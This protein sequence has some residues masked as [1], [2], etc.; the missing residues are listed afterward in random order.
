MATAYHA[1]YFAHE[2]TRR[3]P[4]DS[5]DRL[6]M[7]LFDAAVDLNPHQIDAALFALRS[8]LSKGVLLADE[9]GLGK[10]IEAGLVLC[11]LW[12]ERRRRLLVICPASIR[13]QWSLELQEK[14]NL[15]AVVLDR[16][17]HRATRRQGNPAP[18]ETD[19]I[20]IVS[21]N[22]ASAMQEEVR[23]TAWDLVIIDEAHKLRNAYRPSNRMGQRLRW[24][25]EDRRKVLLTATPLQNTL[26]E[27]YG[28]S[29]L[30]DDHI[31]GDR[32]SFQAQF[33]GQSGDQVELRRRLAGFT[34]RTLRNQVLEY[35]RYT[36]RRALTPCSQS[37]TK[38]RGNSS[39]LA[40][41]FKGRSIASAA[42]LNT[43]QAKK[44][45]ATSRRGCVLSDARWTAA[46]TTTPCRRRGSRYAGPHV[47]G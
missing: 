36:Q 11:Q 16:A 9:V 43:S 10:T 47:R 5:A 27:L 41:G 6:S 17:A 12:A 23:A 2:L 22:F 29:T 4:T 19:A 37:F 1:R 28:L 46:G 3:R 44:R 34:K 14:F 39:R 26:L 45:S 38:R 25:L 7:S 21:M 20:V 31:F 35:V 40:R 8:P 42:T 13:K 32:T 24:A 33:G 18:F 15:P 30:I